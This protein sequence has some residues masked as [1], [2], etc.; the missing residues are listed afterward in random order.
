MS[1]NYARAA[2]VCSMHLYRLGLEHDFL[3]YAIL[4]H[5][6]VLLTPREGLKYERAML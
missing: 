1:I 4:P 3:S 2:A 5:I 6:Q